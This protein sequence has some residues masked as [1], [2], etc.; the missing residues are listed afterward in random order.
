MADPT[1]SVCTPQQWSHAS[2][3]CPGFFL[4]SLRCGVLYSGLHK[5]SSCCQSQSFP[6]GLTSKAR[7]SVPSPYPHWFVTT[8]RQM[9]QAGQCASAPILCAGLSQRCPLYTCCYTL[10]WGSEASHLSPLVRVCSM[11][12][13]I[14]FLHGSFPDSFVSFIFICYFPFALTSYLEIFFPF[15]VQFSS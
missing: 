11:L 5:L 2:L 1:P 9:S 3:A 7:V 8:S 6:W 4:G 10:L 13:K 12:W 14:F 15:Q